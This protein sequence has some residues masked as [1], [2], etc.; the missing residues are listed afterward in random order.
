MTAN[1]DKEKYWNYTASIPIQITCLLYEELLV[2]KQE[3][4]V[5]KQ[6][7]LVKKQELLVKKQELLVKKQELLVKKQELLVKKQEF[8]SSYFSPKILKSMQ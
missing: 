7:L 8:P 4:L 1:Y 2:K 6:E 5:K 3:L